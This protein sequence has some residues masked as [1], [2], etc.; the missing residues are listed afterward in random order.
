M[1]FIQSSDLEAETNDKVAVML[2]AL[3]NPVRLAIVRELSEGS[4]ANCCV[5]FTRHASLAQST[6]SQ[7]LRVLK[8]AGLI[9]YCGDG[10]RSGWCIDRAAMVWLK[11]QVVAL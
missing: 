4:D 7:H 1:E 5:D 9:K 6:V 3:S 10:P 11:Q 8:E 2:K